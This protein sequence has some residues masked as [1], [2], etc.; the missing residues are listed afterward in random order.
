MKQLRYIV[1]AAALLSG[2]AS[3]QSISRQNA[4]N[5][6]LQAQAVDA[7]TR[8]AVK[9]ALRQLAGLAEQGHALPVGFPLAVATLAELQQLQLGWGFAVNDVDANALQAGQP[10]GQTA[11]PS[12]QWRYALL[13]Q[14]KP[15]GLVTIAQGVHGWQVVSFGGTGLSQ[16]IQSVLNRYAGKPQLQLRYVRVPQASSDFIEISQGN[17]PAMY[18]PLQAARQSLGRA[19]PQQALYRA[20]Q[21]APSLR[22]AAARSRDLS[23]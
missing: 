1:F 18:A 21:L 7:P 3:S 11:H 5:F 13:S 19:L 15:V 10:L 8:S 14:G 4:S 6:V 2:A 23:H 9:Q 16:D 20:D 22:T 17:T 12:G